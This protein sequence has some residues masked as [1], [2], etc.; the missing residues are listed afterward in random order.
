MSNIYFKCLCGAIIEE[1]MLGE[2]ELICKKCR[3]A[4][5][6]KYLGNGKYD[7]EVKKEKNVR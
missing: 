5:S 4:L 3:L 7:F 1:E 6:R 2:G